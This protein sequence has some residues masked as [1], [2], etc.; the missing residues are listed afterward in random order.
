MPKLQALYLGEN[1]INVISSHAFNGLKSLLHLDLSHNLVGSDKE[2]LLLERQVFRPTKKLMSLDLSFTKINNGGLSFLYNFRKNLE[3]L[4]LCYTQIPRLRPFAFNTTTLKLLDLSGNPG[5]LQEKD[6]L[7]GLEGYLN[8]LYAD[9]IGL[10][11]VQDFCTFN[12]L[13]VLRLRNNEL[14]AI[15]VN[16]VS[17]LTS[18][19]VLDLTNN[20]LS[21]WFWPLYSVMPNLNVLALRNN[22]LNIISNEMLED[23]RNITYVGIA[24]N[25]VICNCNAREF[26]ELAYKNENITSEIFLNSTNLGAANRIDLMYHRGYEDYNQMIMTRNKVTKP[27]NDT[28]CKDV[29][30][31]AEGKYLLIDFEPSTYECFLVGEDRHVP[32]SAASP[33]RLTKIEDD[34]DDIIY[35]GWNKLLLLLLIPIILC[36]LLFLGFVFR[37]KFIYFCITMR[38]SATLS[39][40]NNSAVPEGEFIYIY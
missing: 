3:R 10:K 31:E 32:F 7:K 23:I 4:S 33:C 21:S 34:P 37:K 16:V 24:E 20:R 35:N 28:E 19:Q 22:N 8:V 18:L 17:T 30:L 26:F 15:S 39:L 38:N 2:N 27:C 6:V 40:I 1:S 36:P 9:E 14:T 13:E 29:D 25:F 12:Q 5:I 11:S